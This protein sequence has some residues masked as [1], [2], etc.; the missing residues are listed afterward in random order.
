MAWRGTIPS[1]I[2]DILCLLFPQFS[3]L[4]P[5]AIPDAMC[6]SPFLEQSLGLDP[7]FSPIYNFRVKELKGWW[8]FRKKERK[9]LTSLFFSLFLFFFF[10]SFLFFFF[11]FLFFFLL[12]FFSHRRYPGAVESLY[13]DLPRQCKI[14]GFRY[15]HP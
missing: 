3:L 8:F 10:F 9:T 4:T 11:F 2:R 7:W 13:D 6:S 1:T 14:C 15:S 5:P 12:L